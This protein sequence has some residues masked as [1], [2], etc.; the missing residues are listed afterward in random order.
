MPLV[1]SFL[2]HDLR[3]DDCTTV[4]LAKKQGKTPI[5]VR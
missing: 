4:K 5:V 1:A 2:C 3:V